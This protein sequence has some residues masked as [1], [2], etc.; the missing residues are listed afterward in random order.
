MGG[1]LRLVWVIASLA[2][3]ALAQTPEDELRLA[4]FKD[5]KAA[6]VSSNNPDPR[7][8]DNSKRPIPGETSV[9]A[10][11]QGTGVITHIWITVAAKEYGWPL[12]LRFRIYY[13][14]SST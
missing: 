10:D 14:G 12:L 6:R 13:Y 5:Y 9:L 3:A 7:S 11:L 4:E 1:R 2:C 8:N